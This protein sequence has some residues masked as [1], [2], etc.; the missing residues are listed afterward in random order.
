MTVKRIRTT[1]FLKK[2]LRTHNLENFLEQNGKQMET[3]KFDKYIQNICKEKKMVRAHVINRA[4]IDKS[5]GYQIFNGIRKPT[6]DKALQIAIAL[7]LDYKE[8]QKLLTIAK[9]HVLHP[10]I[11]RDAVIIHAIENKL[12]VLALQDM[13]YKLTIPLLGEKHD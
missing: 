4:E 5:L 13:L 10:K 8:T 3:H 12:G 2:L 9:K 6:R 1:Y 7:E 11:K